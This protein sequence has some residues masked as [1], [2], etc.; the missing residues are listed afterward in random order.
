MI[1]ILPSSNLHIA[2]IFQS[3]GGR[4]GSHHHD[5]QLRI[6]S[7]N[8]YCFWLQICSQYKM[9]AILQLIFQPFSDFLDKTLKHGESRILK[10]P[11]PH[12]DEI[13]SHVYNRSIYIL[14][15]TTF[16]AVLFRLPVLPGASMKKVNKERKWSSELSGSHGSKKFQ[17]LHQKLNRIYQWKKV[18]LV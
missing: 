18:V 12:S 9:C 1:E 17:R 7:E 13:L 14:T 15:K 6:R 2:F 3:T 8:F 16:A 11:P 5:H 10:I 4:V